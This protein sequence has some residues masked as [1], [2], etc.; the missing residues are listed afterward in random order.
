MVTRAAE[1]MKRTIDCNADR[2]APGAER[3]IRV[4]SAADRDSA[5]PD[6]AADSDS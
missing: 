5:R 2:R 4:T 6:A 1:R 3:Q